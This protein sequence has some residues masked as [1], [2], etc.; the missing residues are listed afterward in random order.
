MFS[1]DGKKARRISVL[2]QSSEHQGYLLQI[3]EEKKVENGANTGFWE[4]WQVDDKPL[5][6]A[7]PS[8]Y[9]ISN[10][11]GISVRE[12]I[13]KGRGH[14]AFRRSL[15]GDTEKLWKSLKERCEEVFMYG[16]RDRPM[17][18]LFADRKFNVKSLYLHLI[19]TDI[20]FSQKFLWKTRVPA[21][22]KS[23]LIMVVE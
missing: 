15:F 14:F 17:W 19:K 16:G 18:M 23:I 10:D 11:H 8:V 13:D 22:I 21:K 20:G 6:E 2:D 9:F 3:C 1:S 7:Y 12:A 4:A 5:K